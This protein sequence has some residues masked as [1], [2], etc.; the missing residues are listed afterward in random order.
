MTLREKICL[1]CLVIFGLL[2]IALGIIALTVIERVVD[3]AVLSRDRLGY[4]NLNGTRRLN[5]MTEKWVAPEYHMQVQIWMFN[6]TNAADV[7]HGAKPRVQEIGPFT[8]MER[9]YKSPYEFQKNETRVFY[10]NNHVYV[11]NE[12]LSCAHCSLDRRVVIPNLV[13]QKLVDFVQLGGTPAKIAIEAVL[14]VLRRESP[15]IDVSVGEALYDG[16]KDPLLDAVCTH[17]V[18]LKKLCEA[19]KIPDRIGFFYGQNNTDDGLYEVS[20]GATN[21]FEIGKVYTFNNMS[22]MPESVWDSADAREIR[23]TDG[24]LF[25]P[26]LEEGQELE[27][28][29]GPMCR[30][31]AMQFLR[32]SEFQ[33]VTAYRYGLPLKMF[34]PTF[35]ENRGFCNRNG[36]PTFFNVSIQIPGCLPKGLLDIGRCLPGT[37]RVYISNSHFFGADPEVFSSIEGMTMPNEEN[38]QTF[39][40]IEPISGAPIFAKRVTQ[41][42]VGM[43]K[44]NLNALSG[45][46]NITIPVLW[47]N[48]TVYFDKDTKDQLSLLTSMK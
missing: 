5:T 4:E 1:G 34:D 31:I 36:T 45:M 8:F 9:Q 19:A 39:V 18:F 15:F 26:M 10:R 11:F 32:R 48:E 24:Q 41:V 29:A 12:S 13:F 17:N 37:P 7:L 2:L 43:L 16:Y 20:T 25:P 46:N 28:F 22:V 14:V 33:G 47:M 40:D 21:V 30:S 27:V 35:P 44:G 42:N 6:L 3:K 38:D 23:G